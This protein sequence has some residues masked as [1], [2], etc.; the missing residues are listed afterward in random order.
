MIKH[1]FASC[2]ILSLLLTLTWANEAKSQ[3]HNWHA[4]EAEGTPQERHENALVRAGDYFIL[5]GGR[6]MKSVDL[7]DTQTGEWSQGAR[8][9]FEIHH[10]QAVEL[11]G[12]V[13]IMGAFTG[14]W[15][16]ETPLSHILIYDPVLD[17]WGIGPKIPPGRRR[18]AA[19]AVVYKDK[20]YLANGIINGHSSGWVSWLD[21]FDPETNSW[22]VLPNAPRERDHF[23]A[24]VIDDK[25]YVAGGRR[26]GYESQ[27]FEATVKETDVF[28]FRTEQWRTLPSPEGDIPTERAGTAAAVYKNNLIIIG[29]ESG[30]QQQ[31]HREVEMLDLSDESWST[32]QPLIRGRHGTQAIYFD[33][34]VFI[35]A[36]S[37]NRGGGPELTSFE[38]FA[39]EPNPEIPS[40]PLTKAII[41][42][43]TNSIR[44]SGNKDGE[45]HQLILKSDEGN[46]AGLISYVQVDN[47][48]YSLS[49]PVRPPFV[50]A[51]G[52]EVP[53]EI[54]WKDTRDEKSAGNLLIKAMGN[55][56]LTVRL[57]VD[58]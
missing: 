15:P 42:V 43:S 52:Q 53:I 19:G 35:G 37:G 34:K 26:S 49:M 24:A 28:D 33:D 54:S 27:G 51:P 22:R 40:N 45:T 12:L 7:V 9:P 17:S 29:G 18:G 6:G 50:L 55:E 13:Y 11:N 14:G 23:H 4:L 8:P 2:I 57:S 3:N 48:N 44:F 46:Q 47:S 41:T 5:L 20:I 36:G 58:N 10:F 39:P 31:A 16:H 30:S 32:L 1:P 21:E 38:V 25:L 56:P